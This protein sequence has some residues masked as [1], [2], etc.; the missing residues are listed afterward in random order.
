MPPRAAS[1]RGWLAVLDR[2]V[3]A[4][5]AAGFGLVMLAIR[6]WPGQVGHPLNLFEAFA[7]YAML[8]VWPALAYAGLRRM[9]GLTASCLCLV[10]AHLVWMLEFVP[11]ALPRVT[12][13]A[14]ADEGV[15]LRMA[16]VNLLAPVGSATFA[17]EIAAMDADVVVASELSDRWAEIFEDEGIY[18][19]Y[20]HVVQEVISERISFFGIGVL[21]RYPITAERIGH[22]DGIP[23]IR[24]DLDVSGAPLR[25]Y[26][27]HAHPPM[28]SEALALWERQLDALLQ[29]IEAD[30]AEGRAVVLTGDFN[31]TAMTHGYR[32]ILGTGLAAGHEAVLRPWAN[33]WPNGTRFFPPVR[34]DHVFVRGVTVRSVREGEGEGSD[35]RPIV[36]DLRLRRS[37]TNG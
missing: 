25:L 1:L 2:R 18:E 29:P 28:G 12:S 3:Y 35:H 4:W 8:P 6:L 37:A 31:T 32:R 11:R 19:R 17:R 5:L 14:A 15:P 20:P 21:S 34:L 36:S 24:V 30:V 23:W 7:G 22:V 10:L 27:F 13:H 26:A 33:T 16:T 9:P